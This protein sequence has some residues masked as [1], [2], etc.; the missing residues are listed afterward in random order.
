MDLITR[1]ISRMEPHASAANPGLDCTKMVTISKYGESFSDKACIFLQ[2]RVKHLWWIGWVFA[3]FPISSSIDSA[4]SNSLNNFR[5]SSDSAA[6]NFAQASW[7]I[8][9]GPGALMISVSELSSY[10]LVKRNLPGRMRHIC[11]LYYMWE[12]MQAKRWRMMAL[13]S[14]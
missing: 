4:L 1:N 10:E 9:C 8:S 11:D 5:W 2:H 13:Q 14:T 7:K 3:W 6:R 12:S